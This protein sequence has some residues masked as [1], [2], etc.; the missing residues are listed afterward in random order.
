MKKLTVL[1]ATIAMVAALVGGCNNTPSTTSPTQ[2]TTEPTTTERVVTVTDMSGDEVTITGEV[3]R[4]INLWPAGTSSFFVMG[5]GDLIVGLAV[6]NPGT[7]N[8]WT[9]L[10]YP[11]CVNIPAMGGTTPS[12]EDLVN[13]DPDLVII[14]PSTAAS[15][16]AQQI[17]NVG[18][19]AININFSNY[20]TMIQAYTILGEVLGG[21]YQQKLN[22]WC[23]AVETKL[24]NV[25]NLTK[26]ISESERPVV[27]YI[28]GQTAS[29]TTTMGADSIV[30]DWV[31]S[32]GGVYGP[33]LIS[34][35]AAEITPEAVFA[36]N[37]D[38]FICGG[39]YQHINKHAVETTDGWKDL[40]PV[41]NN[42]VHTNPYACFNW[43]RFGLES[44]LQINYALMS[45]QPEIAS[46]NGIDRDSMISEIVNFYKTYT[47]Y[48]LS[49]T[50][51]EYMLDGLQPDGTEEFP[52][53]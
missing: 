1:I 35:P 34:L 14:H 6:N 26:N 25:R 17:R 41:T 22:T 47:N 46:A 38:V 21:E 20:E 11:D 7:M 36:L 3:K 19:P 28:A 45:I 15:G 5:A 50:Q 33:R 31:E 53:Q 10:F 44:Q 37:P 49:R 42:R 13:L 12:V 23:N 43:D 4:I 9:R 52:V 18:I 24:A 32:A 40:K 16:L 51:A 29:L 39:V 30:S 8:S 2:T 48:D 27:F